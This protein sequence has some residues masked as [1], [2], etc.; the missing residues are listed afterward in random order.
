MKIKGTNKGKFRIPN[1]SKKQLAALVLAGYLAIN[2]SVALA[3]E[4]EVPVSDNVGAETLLEPP[5]DKITP[6]PTPQPPPK[7]K[8]TPTPP[9]EKTPPPK[10]KKPNKPVVCPCL[11]SSRTGRISLRLPEVVDIEDYPDCLR[12]NGGGRPTIKEQYFL[13]NIIPLE[14]AI[15]EE[16]MSTQTSDIEQS[17]NNVQ[18]N[19][20]VQID[21]K[22]PNYAIHGA[23]ALVALIGAGIIVTKTATNKGKIKAYQEYKKEQRQNAMKRASV[24]VDENFPEISKKERKDRV[25]E[26]TQILLSKEVQTSIGR[27]S[28]TSDLSNLEKLEQDIIMMN[29]ELKQEIENRKMQFLYRAPLNKKTARYTDNGYGPDR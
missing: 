19:D 4:N 22:K 18:V 12:Y 14:D 2:T 23:V 13:G 27:C 8:I 9:P 25:I 3:D 1:L 6:V 28:N 26:G 5:K 10:K 21:N 24:I 11:R 29:P 15:I 16:V 7:D 17:D 20:N